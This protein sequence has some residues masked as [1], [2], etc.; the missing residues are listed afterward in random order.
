[1]LIVHEFISQVDEDYQYPLFGAD[2]NVT[3]HFLMAPQ[4]K[5]HVGSVNVVMSSCATIR[6]NSVIGSFICTL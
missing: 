1:M 2:D 5:D 6:Y 4:S 3:S